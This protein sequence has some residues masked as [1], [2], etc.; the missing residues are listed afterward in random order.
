MPIS[1]TGAK[2]YVER[3]RLLFF[4]LPWTFTKYTLNPKKLLINTGL[5]T[6]V[7]NEILLY[8]V[9]DITVKRSLM[10]KIFRLGS[11][12]VISSDKTCPNLEIK[13]IRNVTQ[14]REALSEYIEESRRQYRMR[15]GEIIDDYDGPGD[16]MDF[17]Q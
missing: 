5:L 2:I 1:S 9:M 12:Q 6:S 11:I 15:A 3:K 13:N 14:F 7:E 10:Q 8:R 4:G 16:D 17:D